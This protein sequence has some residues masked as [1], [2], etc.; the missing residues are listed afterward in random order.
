MT[1]NI[2]FEESL[3]QEN[4]YLYNLS[5]TL[6]HI[7]GF[8]EHKD[9]DSIFTQEKPLRVLYVNLKKGLILSIK[10]YKIKVY[11]YD[12]NKLLKILE[13][14]K[15]KLDEE[16]IYNHLDDVIKKY[17]VYLRTFKKSTFKEIIKEKRG[18]QVKIK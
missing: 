11:N 17:K 10:D 12:K 9:Y 1:N 7:D 8:K 5:H 18:E 16:E 6:N 14:L 3:N 4:P 15:T 13:N 2:I